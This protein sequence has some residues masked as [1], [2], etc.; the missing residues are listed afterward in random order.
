MQYARA[1]R[2]AYG[3]AAHRA[4]HQVLDRG[5]IFSDP[6]ARAILGPGGEEAM[7]QRSAPH[8]KLSRLFFAVRSRFAEDSLAAAWKRG[9]RQLVVLGAGLD[10][11]AL[12]N[13]HTGLAVF[14]VDHPA[15]QTWRRQ[16]LADANLAIPPSLVFAPVNFE[17]QSLA[18]QLAA[19]GFDAGK[20]SFFIWLGVMPYLTLPAIH[21]TLDFVAAVPQ[22][23]TVFDY[24]EPLEHQPPEARARMDAAAARVA[25]AGEPWISH[26]EPAALA[27]LLRA[28]GFTEIEDLGPADIAQRYF[29]AGPGETRDLVSARV[30]RARKHK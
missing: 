30:L 26:F 27:G 7:A 15:T 11:F 20:P 10:T 8:H 17:H 16:C 19:A 18:A 29:K 14:E 5:N 13:P 21:A 4:V 9:T 24:V 1:S 22:A 23:E 3:V 25:A 6:F 12:R 28:K 2:T